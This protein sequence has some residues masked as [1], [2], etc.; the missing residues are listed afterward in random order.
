VEVL[1]HLA[2]SHEIVVAGLQLAGSSTQKPSQNELQTPDNALEPPVSLDALAKLSQVN[3][4]RRSI[5]DAIATNVV[6]LGYS[7]DVAEDR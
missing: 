5:I 3:S 7:I 6:G 4:L 2:K 1:E